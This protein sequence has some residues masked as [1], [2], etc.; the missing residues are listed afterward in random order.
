[1]EVLVVD[2][3]GVARALPMAECV[4]VME[5]ALASLA[6]GEAAMPLRQMAELP[7][8]NLLASMPAMIPAGAAVKV[9]TVFP[10]NAGTG[11][12]SHQ[13]AV[14][15]FEPEHGSLVTIADA[16]AVTAIR[17]A[18]VSA[19]ATRAL[20][21]DDAGDLAIL[22]S[23]TQ[24]RT[25]LEA[26]RAVREVRRVRAWSRNALRAMEF[27]ARESE[28]TGLSVEPAPSARDAVEGADIICTVTAASE[29]ILEGAWLSPGAHVNAVGYSG[30][31]GREVDTEAVRRSRLYVD[32]RES[33]L[34][35]GGD[36]A[37]PVAEGAIGEDHIVGELG[38]VLAGTAPGRTS[39][40]DIT[41]FESLGLS[42][43]DA[44]AVVRIHAVA[45]ARGI[46]VRVPFARG[47]SD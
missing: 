35:E 47:P 7:G 13:G 46:G 32:R 11:I 18:A 15:L 37:I 34:T 30:P 5:E 43:E 3:A 39:P 33:A 12:E 20:A 42:V 2:A 27:A 22:G 8:G 26:M 23:G 40:D 38:E 4:E 31:I 16:G 24:A 28:R 41:F 21:R 29:P 19:V 36:V 44:A 6:R 45:A 17:T 10:G 9:I 25:H 14:L 1:M